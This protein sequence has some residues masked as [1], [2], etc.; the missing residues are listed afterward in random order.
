M[1]KYHFE[2]SRQDLNIEFYKVYD[3]NYL[4]TKAITLHLCVADPGTTTQVLIEKGVEGLQVGAD[5]RFFDRLHADLHFTEFHQFE[6]MLA[7][8]LAAFQDLPHWVF[9]TDYSPG[10]VEDMA[11][12][13]L[14]GNVARLTNEQCG[15]FDEFI[16]SVVYAGFEPGRGDVQDWD[17]NIRN[18][19]CFLEHVA[20][21]YLDGLAAY[22]A[23]KHGLRLFVG[24][25][26]M[27]ASLDG[28]PRFDIARVPDTIAYLERKKVRKGEYELDQVVVEI[29]PEASFQFIVVMAHI[30]STVRA[31]R[32]R[33]M[34]Q[35]SGGIHIF[36]RVTPQ[37]I[38]EQEGP[39]GFS[40]RMSV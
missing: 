20:R 26:R 2:R 14:A 25:F 13:L 32:L 18:L 12:E 28:Q 15:T 37:W 7:L 8:L 36:P 11:K 4:L 6:G 3:A 29:R 10:W 23:Y 17:E 31:T 30:L 16:R 39:S 33:A 24:P 21:R 22:N 35:E 1:T 38:R 5:D 27:S 9:M 34:G 19:R 40:L